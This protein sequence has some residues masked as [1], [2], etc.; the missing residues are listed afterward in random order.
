MAAREHSPVGL[1]ARVGA[2]VAAKVRPGQSVCAAFSGG[3]DSTVLLDILARLRDE[4]GFAL[5]ALH[6]HHGLSRNADRWAG[7][8]A[9]FAAS[10]GVPLRVERVT[11]DR[12]HPS[13]LEAAA[14]VARHAA[15]AKAGT[16]FVALAHHRDDQAETVLLQAL[17]GTGMKGLSAMAEARAVG[18]A[19]WL[20]PLL[21]EPRDT[22]FE[23]ARAAGLDWVE[24]ESNE[25]T[26]FDRNF[27][28][29]EVMPVLGRRFPQY[30]ESLA[31]L[32]RHAASASELLETLAREDAE[33]IAEGG[34][35]SAEGLAALDPLRRANVLRHFLAARGL[36]MPGDA[37]LA[38][39]ARQ[40]VSA[41]EDARVLLLHGGRALVRHRGVILV[42][43]PP[44]RASWEIAWHGEAELSL[45][46]GRGAVRFA[47][48]TGEGIALD[49]V[50]G[51]RW[52]FAS[53]AGGERI[54][55]REGGPTRTLKNLLQE[56][57]V[58]AWRRARLPLL[59][60]GD[61]LVWVP[62]IGIAADFHARGPGLL[63]Q[64][65]GSTEP[66]CSANQRV[67][68][69]VPE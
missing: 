30:R 60:E 55:L 34:G 64:W 62:G 21:D 69:E 49:R 17:R 37:R 41:R 3:L 4:Q 22:L 56:H 47:S 19:V 44:R 36:P 45:G 7:A 31:R 6:V 68:P 33:R 40:L 51:G 28:R 35:V 43:E 27:L 63:P 26:A 11:V 48:A 61:R 13:G 29:H 20:R 25:L 66:V 32:A 42:E 58:P 53:R 5:A 18:G 67:V 2:R 12:D 59:F 10:R 50:E 16:D 52:R 9:A 8:C 46:A 15:F 23:H 39:M 1:L 24:D 57:A 14:R 54:R 38:D 65:D